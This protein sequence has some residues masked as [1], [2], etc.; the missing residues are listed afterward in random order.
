MQ[1]NQRH[2]NLNERR[3]AML[4]L[5]AFLLPV[6]VIFLG[7]SVDLAYMQCVRMEMRVATDAAARA[8]ASELAQSGDVGKARTAAKNMARDNVVANAPLKIRNADVDFGRSEPDAAGKWTFTKGQRPYN[9][10][11]VNGSRDANSR[12]GAIPLFFSSFYGGGNFEPGLSSTASFLNVDVCLVLDRSTSMKL[13]TVTK[14]SGMYTSDPRFCRPP[15]A[16][17]RWMALDGAVRVFAKLL[18]TTIG[19][20]QVALATYSSGENLPYCGMSKKASSLDSQLTTDINLIDAA[21]DDL[22]TTVW[23]G[24]TDIESGMRTGLAELQDASRART[25]ADKYMIVM[26]DG[27]QNRGDCVAAAA[28]CAAANVVVHAVTFSDYADR[29]RMAEVARVGGGRYLHASNPAEL[30]EAFRTLA[31]QI[32]QITE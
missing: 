10:V 6:L 19:E 16:E 12:G 26:T 29:G 2:A 7:F 9:S 23:N 8:G 15:N 4:P 20:E 14:E 24:N 25:T 11:R 31:A 28:D 3:G 21:M 17:S 13:S 27:H 5:I 32:S 1:L 18:R 22:A 30:E